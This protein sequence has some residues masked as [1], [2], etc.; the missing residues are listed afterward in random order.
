MKK[1]LS[2]R[3][4]RFKKKKIASLKDSFQKANAKFK[5]LKADKERLNLLSYHPTLKPKIKLGK[6]ASM[7]DALGG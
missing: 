4:S 2:K 3:I 7:G 6:Y 5:Q 1:K